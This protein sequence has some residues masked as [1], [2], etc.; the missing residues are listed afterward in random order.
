MFSFRTWTND[1]EVFFQNEGLHG[2]L[3]VQNDSKPLLFNTFFSIL[4]GFLLSGFEVAK[5]CLYYIN[6]FSSLNQNKMGIETT[7]NFMLNMKPLRKR[8]KVAN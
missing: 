8:E 7:Q 3:R 6:I 4:S 5:K 2:V 1:Y